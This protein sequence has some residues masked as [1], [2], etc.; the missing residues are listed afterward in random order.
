MKQQKFKGK[1]KVYSGIN[2]MVMQNERGQNTHD[3]GE[4]V[5]IPLLPNNVGK[6]SAN[7]A[8]PQQGHNMGQLRLKTNSKIYSIVFEQ[9]MFYLWNQKIYNPP[10]SKAS[11]EVA[12]LIEKMQHTHA[13]CEVFLRKCLVWVP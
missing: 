6:K 7:N 13:C 2:Q 1:F 8:G 4:M 9:S 12:N 5:K 3:Q 10:A 11:S